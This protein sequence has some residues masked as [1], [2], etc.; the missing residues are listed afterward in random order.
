MFSDLLTGAS[1]TDPHHWLT[2][3]LGHVFVGVVL[4]LVIRNWKL[5][6]LLYAGFEVV[7]AYVSGVVLFWDSVLDTVAVA[8][9]LLLLHVLWN[10]DRNRALLV[11]AGIS[12]IGLVGYQKKSHRK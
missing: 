3:F 12:L 9:G 11:V 5:S 6:L 2:T 1:Q 7:Q 4:A 10:R 8:L